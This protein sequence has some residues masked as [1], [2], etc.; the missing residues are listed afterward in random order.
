MLPSVDAETEHD[1][2]G[3][4]EVRKTR[5]GEWWQLHGRSAV[6]VRC[7]AVLPFAECVGCHGTE[8]L[9][10]ANVVSECLAMDTRMTGVEVHEPQLR[11]VGY[12]AVCSLAGGS[13]DMSRVR[14]LQRHWRRVVRQRLT[15]AFQLSPTRRIESDIWWQEP[16]HD[17]RL[18]RVTPLRGD[19]GCSLASPF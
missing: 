4:S 2:E 10:H 5:K 18:H 7:P 6:E 11:F 1:P 9:R 15:M 3:M 12:A 16:V 14:A 8:E 17:G 13:A 19:A